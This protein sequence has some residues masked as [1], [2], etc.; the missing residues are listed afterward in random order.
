MHWLFLFFFRLIP[1][2]AD[3]SA[4]GGNSDMVFAFLMAEPPSGTDI[5]ALLRLRHQ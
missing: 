2:L 5:A 1:E 3:G 4:I